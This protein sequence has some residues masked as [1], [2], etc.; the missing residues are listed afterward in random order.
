MKY[1]ISFREGL[2]SVLSQSHYPILARR[3]D[4]TGPV[5]DFFEEIFNNKKIPASVFDKINEIPSDEFSAMIGQMHELY[6]AG[7]H[8]DRKQEMILILKRNLS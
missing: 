1:I 5:F 4:E 7:F 2:K 6:M 3:T 8:G